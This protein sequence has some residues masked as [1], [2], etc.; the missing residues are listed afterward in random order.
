MD[1]LAPQTEKRKDP[2]IR[3][4]WPVSI[5]TDRGVIQGES[6]NITITG[7]FINCEEQL[8]KNETYRMV[9]TPPH[10]QAFEVKGRVMWS[11][12]EGVVPKE[13]LFGM[14]FSFVKITDE[15]RHRLNDAVCRH[16][17]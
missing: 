16:L 13:P 9:I 4:R 1:G 10:H 6:R 8:R 2:R 11:N 12:L 3:A 14:G 5:I 15:D 17:Q 7:V